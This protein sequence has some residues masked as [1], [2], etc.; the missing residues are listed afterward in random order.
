MTDIIH[1]PHSLD[2]LTDNQLVD[3]TRGGNLD[4]YG[5]LYSRHTIA[6]VRLARYYKAG[7]D[8]DD[9]A[10]EAFMAV[11]AAIQRGKGPTESFSGYLLTAVRRDGSAREGGEA[12]AAGCGRG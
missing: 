1:A 7:T 4:A 9:V 5:V 11:L 3:L 2:D 6:A 12:G 10:A 8:A